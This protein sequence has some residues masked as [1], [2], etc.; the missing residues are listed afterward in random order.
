M[1]KREFKGESLQYFP[2]SYIIIDTETTGLD[3]KRDAIIEIAALKVV[4]GTIIDTY[5]SLINPEHPVNFFVTELTGITNKELSEAPLASE[6]LPSF[7]D[8]IEDFILVGHNVNFDI[9]FLYDHILSL[10]GKYVSNDYVDTLY[11]SRRYYK[12]VPNH[13]L[14]TLSKFLEI[15]QNTFHRALSD[16]MTTFSL[17][18]ILEE[19]SKHPLK[20]EEQLLDTLNIGENNPFYEKR[21]LIHGTPQ[22]YTDFFIKS[23]IRKCHA[24]LRYSYQHYDLVILSKFTYKNYIDGMYTKTFGDGSIEVIS[25]EDFYT[26]LSI[27]VPTVTVSKKNLSI[28]DIVPENTDFDE[29]HPLYNKLCVF[30]GT[31]ERMS[32]KTAMQLVVNL[33]GSIGSSVTKKTNYLILG[34]ND[35]CFSIKDGKSAKQKKAESLKL[36]GQDIEIIS[37]DVFY[38]MIENN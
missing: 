14:E 3:P 33:G 20:H 30:T 7:Y 11:I 13:K 29:T 2:D 19:A 23:V 25:E 21:I 5:S 38:D 28:K 27:P 12:N 37:E 16:C 36:S 34:N 18:N 22:I 35:Y 1:S 10:M 32:R 24:K 17:Y 9:N 8:F 4:N 15:E 26:A 31:L 6:V